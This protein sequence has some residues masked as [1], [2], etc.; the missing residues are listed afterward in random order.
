MSR[1]G[2]PKVVHGESFP[3]PTKEYATWKGIQNRCR[4]NSKDRERYFDRGIRVC[5]RWLE[6]YENFL[7]DMGR[8]PS[9]KHSIERRDNSGNYEPGNCIWATVK[10]QGNN[11]RN[12][13]FYFLDGQKFN[14][15]ELAAYLQ[16]N[17]ASIWQHLKNGKSLEWIAE[18]FKSR[19]E[20]G[21]VGKKYA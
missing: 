13:H 17:T 16:C 19:I 10:A 21:K 5:D 2:Q 9:S 15:R 1:R 20:A 18:H 6:G 14:I 4:P 8:A 7:A 11:K 3:K 12:N